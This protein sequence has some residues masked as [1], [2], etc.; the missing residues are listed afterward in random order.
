MIIKNTTEIDSPPNPFDQEVK[1]RV[2]SNGGDRKLQLAAN[3]FMV[4]SVEAKYSYNFQ[5]LGRPIIQ[6]PQDIQVMQEIIWS[7]KPDLIIATGI[8]NGGSLIFHSSMLELNAAC[9][10]PIDAKVI[11]VDV[12]IRSHNKTAIER[13]PMSRRIEMIQGSSIDPDVI[14]EIYHL[15]RGRRRILVFLDSNH[16]HDHVLAE[17]NAYSPLVSCGSYCVVFDTM[18]EDLPI[19]QIAGRPWGKG[20]NPKTA[21]KQFLRDVEECE[22]KGVDGIRLKFEIDRAIDNKILITFAPEG[23]LRRIA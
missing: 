5:W 15:A 13:H 16:T 7:V 18:V 14:E 17:L 22:K 23:F 4:A 20:N 10:G 11:G 1:E 19:D 9:G 2:E 6:N 3:Q 21:V 8:A 12:D